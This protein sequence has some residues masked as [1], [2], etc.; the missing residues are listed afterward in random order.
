MGVPLAG[1]SANVKI[2]ANQIAWMNKWVMTSKANVKET[3][4]FQ[5][6]GQY[7]TQSATTK[8]WSVKVDGVLDATDTNGQVA[9]I[10]GLGTTF[11]L[12]LDT[13]AAGTHKWTGSAILVGIDPT[14]DTKDVNLIVFAFEGTGPATFT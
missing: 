10:N 3:T 7:K 1:V 9:L 14:S 12:E 5:A 4:S 8:E 6:S 13:D 11:S 2:G